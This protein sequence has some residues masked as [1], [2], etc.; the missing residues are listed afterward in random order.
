MTSQSFLK[1]ELLRRVLVFTCLFWNR[2]CTCMWK[3]SWAF[4]RSQILSRSKTVKTMDIVCLIYLERTT[5]GGQTDEIS[6]WRHQMETFSALY[7]PFVLG[8]HRSP[9]NSPHKG[10]WRGAF[11]LRQN[12][13]LIKQSRRWWFETPLRWLWRHFNVQALVWTMEKYQSHEM[14][15]MSSLSC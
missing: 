13:R 12:K 1:N 7:W 14:G 9:V 11:Y 8:I 3:R 5:A 2:K 6:W 10:Q 4:F 15:M